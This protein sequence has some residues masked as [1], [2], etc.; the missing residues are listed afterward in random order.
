MPGHDCRALVRR[1]C[2]ARFRLSQGEAFLRIQIVFADADKRLCIGRCTATEFLLLEMSGRTVART[3]DTLSANFTPNAMAD[4][5]NETKGSLLRMKV[6]KKC[7]RLD[8]AIRMAKEH[9]SGPGSRL[10]K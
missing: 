3:G 8:E 10:V 9:V 2:A 1:D 5:F 4:V 7:A 6:L